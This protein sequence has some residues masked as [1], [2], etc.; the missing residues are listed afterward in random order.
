MDL[1]PMHRRHK[2]AIDKEIAQIKRS[3][4]GFRPSVASYPGSN[5]EKVKLQQKFSY[6][7]GLILPREML[8][9]AGILISPLSIQFFL[10]NVNL[11][12]TSR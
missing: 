2:E 10:S 11:V 4:E 12:R 7:P 9:G 5:A 8:P 6:S 1:L 3:V